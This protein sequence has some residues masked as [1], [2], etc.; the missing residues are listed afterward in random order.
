[1]NKDELAETH[2]KGMWG[3]PSGRK[4]KRICTNTPLKL[5]M[6]PTK[7]RLKLWVYTI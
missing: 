6:K 2:G 3:R 7:A 1:M 4:T 5:D